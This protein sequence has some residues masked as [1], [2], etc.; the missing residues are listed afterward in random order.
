ML[1]YDYKYC[2][3]QSNIP[4]KF[5]LALDLKKCHLGLTPSEAFFAVSG[6]EKYLGYICLV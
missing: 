5:F 2:S 6:K 3:R 1:F 4:S